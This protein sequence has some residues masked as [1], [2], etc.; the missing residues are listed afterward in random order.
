MKQIL[1]ECDRVKITHVGDRVIKEYSTPKDYIDETWLLYYQ[2]YASRYSGVVK[3]YEADK[4]HIM[5][6][7]IEG[8]NLNYILWN[9]PELGY[10]HQF[11]YKSFTAILQSL[12]NMAEFSSTKKNEWFHEDAG[13]HNFMYTGKE[14]ILIDPDSFALNDNPYPGTFVSSLHPLHNILEAVHTMHRTKY[15]EKM[16]LKEKSPLHLKKTVV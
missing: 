14:F 15:E 3:V 16:Q 1:K 10:N 13:T 8:K 9:E 5:M 2:T 7:Y 12:T 11:I 6:D 4:H